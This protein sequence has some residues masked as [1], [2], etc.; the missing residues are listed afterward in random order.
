MVLASDMLDMKHSRPC[1]TWWVTLSGGQDSMVLLHSLHAWCLAH[2]QTLH[3]IHVNHAYTKD[4]DTWQQHCQE[5]CDALGVPLVVAKMDAQNLAHKPQS[6]EAYWRDARYQLIKDH[7]QSEDLICLAHHQEDQ[8]ETVLM[9]LLRGSG[10]KGLAAMKVLNHRLDRYWYRPLLHAPKAT[11]EQYAKDYALRWIDDPSNKDIRF[12]RNYLRQHILPVIHKHWPQASK[13]IEKSSQH[14]LEDSSLLEHYL[15]QDLL[16]GLAEDGSLCLSFWQDQAQAKQIPLLRYWLSRY[17]GYSLPMT[18]W[19]SLVHQLSAWHSQMHISFTTSQGVIRVYKK[20]LYWVRN[21]AHNSNVERYSWDLSLVPQCQ[22]AQ[23][24]FWAKE[25]RPVELVCGLRQ[26]FKHLRLSH[27][28][29][30]QSIKNI[31][32]SL[33]VPPWLRDTLPLLVFHDT[34]VLVPGYYRAKEY[35]WIHYRSNQ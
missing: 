26:D 23:M 10:A 14:C 30:R 33:H 25:L 9:R 32:Q 5:Q 3:A 6:L 15:H 13:T 35:E 22:F 20:R 24:T 31:L 1:A 27:D 2:E 17:E 7:T 28:R 8:V 29:P 21:N 12:S 18:Q 16:H 11:I 19:T 4:A 34:L